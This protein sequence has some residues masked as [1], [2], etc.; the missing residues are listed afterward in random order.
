MESD[1]KEVARGLLQS[2]YSQWP[3]GAIELMSEDVVVSASD[4]KV[5]I[6]HAGAAQW[7]ANNVH[8]YKAREF[9]EYRVEQLDEHWVLGAGAVRAELRGGEVQMRPGCWLLRVVDGLVNAF[10]YYRTA[11]SAKDALA[12]RLN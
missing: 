6:G 11:E 7:Y 10:L 2:D 12:D 3:A 8:S 4:G 9:I 5:Y 1:A